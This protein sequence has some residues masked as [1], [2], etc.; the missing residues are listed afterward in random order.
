[1]LQTGPRKMPIVIRCGC[2]KGYRVKDALAGKMV[3]CK[4]CDGRIRVPVFDV[5]ENDESELELQSLPSTRLKKGGSSEKVVATNTATNRAN[6]KKQRDKAE[7]NEFVIYILGSLGTAL[8][9]V[10]IASLF[11]GR[12]S[13]AALG[14]ALAMP[15]LSLLGCGIGYF[16]LASG[17]HMSRTMASEVGCALMLIHGWAVILMPWLIMLFGIFYMAI[18]GVVCLLHYS[19]YCWALA[20]F[21]IRPQQNSK[22]LYAMLGDSMTLNT[23]QDD[24]GETVDTRTYET[25]CS[26]CKEIVPT[27]KER[28]NFYQ[29]CSECGVNFKVLKVRVSRS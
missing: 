15:W 9:S 12:D 11:V 21:G 17:A 4:S 27:T 14:W 5:G 29:E 18:F 19:L 2:G 20:P 25:R 26:E 24:V 10:V 3:K 13:L 8:I 28:K 22:M 23:S 6:S 16:A 7:Y 1:M